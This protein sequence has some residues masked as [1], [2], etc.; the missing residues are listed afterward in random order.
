MTEVAAV[1]EQA[2][3]VDL[4]PPAQAP[5]RE[6]MAARN[7]ARAL[8]ADAEDLVALWT[9]ARPMV[10]AHALLA[11]YFGGHDFDHLPRELHDRREPVEVETR[12]YTLHTNLGGFARF[13]RQRA[14]H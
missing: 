7:A 14:G 5:D 11:S 13:L 9:D 6:A 12:G 1:W 8:G 3:R 4:R 2:R 10:A